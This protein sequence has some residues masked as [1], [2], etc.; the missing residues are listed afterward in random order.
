MDFSF[1]QDKD[2]K[3][4]LTFSR[5]FIFLA[6]SS[7]YR[8]GRDE[9]LSTGIQKSSRGNNP[10]DP[11]AAIAFLRSA[12]RSSQGRFSNGDETRREKGVRL[13]WLVEFPSVSRA[14]SPRRVA[15]CTLLNA[16]NDLTVSPRLAPRPPL[17]GAFLRP[18]NFRL[19]R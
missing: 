19:N 6:S 15:T 3:G 12:T 14:V 16:I 5:Y 2:R 1:R 18:P 11:F 10:S 8:V 17:N 4:A 13:K 9:K 7:S